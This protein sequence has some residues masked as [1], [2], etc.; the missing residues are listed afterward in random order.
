MRRLL[1]PIATL[2]AGA[3]G[4]F[5]GL[6]LATVDVGAAVSGAYLGAALG[7]FVAP[8][9]F[10]AVVRRGRARRGMMAQGL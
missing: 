3:L 9:L 2:V 8:F 6:G 10:W 7:A 4:L 5:I 1:D